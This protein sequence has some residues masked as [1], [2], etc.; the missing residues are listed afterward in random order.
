MSKKRSRQVQPTSF[1]I[2]AGVLEK[3]QAKARIAGESLSDVV[4]GS[5][6][7]YASANN[8]LGACDHLKLK[9]KPFP[10]GHSPVSPA[11]WGKLG[12]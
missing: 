10:A 5:L 9:M 7:R 11:A 6:A 4:S 8:V 12:R 1:R 3:A 2:R